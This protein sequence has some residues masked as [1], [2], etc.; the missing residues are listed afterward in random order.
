MYTAQ[1]S[2]KNWCFAWDNDPEFQ[3]ALRGEPMSE[4]PKV[5]FE[6]PKDVSESKDDGWTAA[7]SGRKKKKR[8]ARI[9]R[10]IQ[11]N[12]WDIRTV[13]FTAEERRQ[14]EATCRVNN[15]RGLRNGQWRHGDGTIHRTGHTLHFG[16]C[17]EI[18]A[19]IVLRATLAEDPEYAGWTVEGPDFEHRRGHERDRGD[20]L[21][22]GP[23]GEEVWIE[24]K[25]ITNHGG[26]NKQ[27]I[28]HA[29]H[30]GYV[31]QRL[32]WTFQTQQLEL[33]A[34]FDPSHDDYEHVMNS[35]LIGVVCTKMKGGGLALTVSKS[36]FLEPIHTLEWVK[37]RYTS[38]EDEGL[39]RATIDPAVV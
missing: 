32:K 4:E 14:V 35:L 7:V 30:M 25:T 38:K 8:D 11:S 5:V 19:A 31:F 24:V 34:T 9:E 23:D 27:D 3:A 33:S 18:A 37:L 13:F 16:R 12:E 29:G 15:V 21:V 2:R 20:L 17:G 22:L 36:V 28:N 1:K 39:K 6:E 26:Y 10:K